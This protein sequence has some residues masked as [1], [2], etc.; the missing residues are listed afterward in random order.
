MGI[1]EREETTTG[2]WAKKVAEGKVQP[3]FSLAWVRQGSFHSRDQNVAAIIAVW[4]SIIAS[5]MRLYV[6]DRIWNSDISL[7]TLYRLFG[8]SHKI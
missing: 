4:I 7:S 6:F 3:P 1:D 5:I 8:V 2:R